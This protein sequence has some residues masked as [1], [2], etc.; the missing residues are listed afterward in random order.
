MEDLENK[1]FL[2]SAQM[3][4]RHM[5]RRDQFTSEYSLS[6]VLANL[7]LLRKRAELRSEMIEDLKNLEREV[8]KELAPSP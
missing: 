7:D 8:L 4:Q 3:L 2:Q 5:A 6:V 1:F